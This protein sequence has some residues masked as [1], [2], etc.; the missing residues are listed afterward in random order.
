[1][2]G[3]R[4]VVPPPQAGAAPAADEFSGEREVDTRTVRERLDPA[5]RTAPGALAPPPDWPSEALS[6]PWR[7]HGKVAMLGASAVFAAADLLTIWNAFA[8]AVVK[9]PLLVWALAWQTR[10]LLSTA[11][12]SDRPP[13][14]W[15]PDD[16]ESGTLSVLARV[17]LRTGLYLVPA[18]VAWIVPYLRDPKVGHDA[19][20]WTIAAA[21]AAGALLLAPVVLL[22]SAT[23]NPR[24]TWPW[25]A[26]PWLF[27]GLR[28][29]LVAAG[30]WLA[31]VGVEVLVGRFS[32][33]SGGAF[34]ASFAMRLVALTLVLTGGRALG[35]LGRRYAL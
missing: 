15:K 4:A 6:Y 25:G 21:W 27:R 2:P 29:V 31:L 33:P 12:G 26:F 20:S 30:S 17:G 35:V 16:L 10:A 9:V 34:L 24:M 8:G 7:E 1:V 32:A 18:L 19:R 3:E 28:V 14:A 23:G 22:G 11:L 13:R 5:S